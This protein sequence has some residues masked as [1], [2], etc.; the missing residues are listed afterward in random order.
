MKARQ[1]LKT[2]LRLAAVA[3]TMTPAAAIASDRHPIGGN[4]LLHRPARDRRRSPHGFGGGY[5]HAF[6]PPATAP[7]P[8]PV[9]PPSNDNAPLVLGISA[10]ILAA[11]LGT[12]LV[13]RNRRNNPN[14]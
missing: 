10:A 8:T 6:G 12:R 9:P 13:L 3:A 4:V 7:A 11:A 14:P 1:T 2:R 5:C